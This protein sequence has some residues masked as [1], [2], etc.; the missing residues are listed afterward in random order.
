VHR[1]RSLNRVAL[2][3]CI[4]IMCLAVGLGIVSRYVVGRPLLWTDEVARLMLVWLTFVGAAQLFSYQSG[5]LTLAFVTER[6]GERTRRWL[7][8]GTSFVEL[9]LMLVVAA[10][11]LLSIYY[12]SEAVSS[13]LALP[14]YV[15]YGV[16][17]LA[18]LASAFF[19]CHKL[20]AYARGKTPDLVPPPL[21]S[22]AI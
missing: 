21:E 6:L 14:H 1:L 22:E 15:V 20:A 2:G 9:I 13:A 17:P 8:F 7:A 5:H 4:I 12:N 10:G 3:T 18:A 11:A 19:I 16:L